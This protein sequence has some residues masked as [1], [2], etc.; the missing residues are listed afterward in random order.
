MVSEL[1]VKKQNDE[2]KVLS[3]LVGVDWVLSALRVKSPA[4]STLGWRRGGCP[5]VWGPLLA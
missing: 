5:W 2:I 4:S 3:G 1:T